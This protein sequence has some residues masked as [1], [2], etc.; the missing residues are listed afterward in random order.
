MELITQLNKRYATKVFDASKKLSEKD[1]NNLLEAIRLSASSYGFQAYKILVV[2]NAQIRNQ[3]REAAWNQSQITDSSQL[4]VF[5]VD[6]KFDEKGVDQFVELTAKT[7]GLN[8]EDLA[9][10]ANMMKGSFSNPREQ[11]VAWLTRQVYIALGFGLVASAAMNI[12][13]CPMEGFDNA[14]FDKILGLEEL[15]LKS[16]ALLAVGYRSDDDN[17]QHLAKVRKTKEELFIKI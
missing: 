1:L 2:E 13:S 3:L 12:D 14:S 16:V 11:V 9:S 15:G 6:T 10:Y 5:A 4:L 8:V 7:R 17:Y